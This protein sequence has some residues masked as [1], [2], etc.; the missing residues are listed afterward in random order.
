MSAMSIIEVAIG[1]VLLIVAIVSYRRGSTQGAVLLIV[2]A[3]LL[4]IHGFGLME[5]RPSAA[6]ISQ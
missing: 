6:E 3:L 2:V 1:A 4:L 5:Y